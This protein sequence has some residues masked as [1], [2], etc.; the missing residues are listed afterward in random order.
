[1]LLEALLSVFTPGL[2][3]PV[4][5]GPPASGLRCY[6]FPAHVLPATGG[7]HLLGTV[8]DR[9]SK[10]RF[11]FRSALTLEIHSQGIWETGGVSATVTCEHPDDSESPQAWPCTLGHAFFT[12]PNQQGPLVL[13]SVTLAGQHARCLSCPLP[14]LPVIR[15]YTAASV[16]CLWPW[17]MLPPSHPFVQD[18]T[19][20]QVLLH[21]GGLGASRPQAPQASSTPL[22]DYSSPS[23]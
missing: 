9:V 23:L 6:L 21:Q 14:S 22:P 10:S 12:T 4:T 11:H 19:P 3:V 16:S 17:L 13:S 7:E 20:S 18:L 5:S 1:M 2:E 8:T 15:H